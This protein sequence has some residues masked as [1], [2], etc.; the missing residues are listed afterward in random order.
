MMKCLQIGIVEAEK[1][2]SWCWR[3]NPSINVE[4]LGLFASTP[5]K[6]FEGSQTSNYASDIKFHLYLQ[7]IQIV[8]AFSAVID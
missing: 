7:F 3:S 2:P 6:V 8:D 1:S 4:E 5:S